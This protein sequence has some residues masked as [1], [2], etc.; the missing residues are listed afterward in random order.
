MADSMGSK[1]GVIFQPNDSG[2]PNFH[3]IFIACRQLPEKV[4]QFL[5]KYGR[6]DAGALELKDEGTGVPVKGLIEG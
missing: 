4:I 6:C 3:G 1:D 5:Q 2:I